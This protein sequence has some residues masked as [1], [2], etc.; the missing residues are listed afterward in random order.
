M[1][2]INLK[3]I[4]KSVIITS[5]FLTIWATVMVNRDYQIEHD[6]IETTYA[7]SIGLENIHVRDKLIIENIEFIFYES[8]G[9]FGVLRFEK[10]LNNK[11]RQ[12]GNSISTEYFQIV[13]PYIDNEP[14]VIIVGNNPTGEKIAC[15]ILDRVMINNVSLDNFMIIFSPDDHI[16]ISKDDLTFL[17]NSGEDISEQIKVSY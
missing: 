15:E 5:I 4:V 10:G 9:I 14:Y 1:K 6:A 13:Q 8:D 7:E 11:Y 17:N 3:K 2:Y 16:I 12:I